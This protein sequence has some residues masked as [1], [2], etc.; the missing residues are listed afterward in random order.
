M[1]WMLGRITGILAALACLAPTLAL[2]DEVVHFGPVPAWVRPTTLPTSN[3]RFEGPVEVLLLDVESR[4][5]PEGVETFTD[6]AFRIR[7][8]AGLA[9]AGNVL[10]A[11]DPASDTLTVHSLQII[12]NGQTTDITQSG[13]GFL[14]LR[15][16]TD[17]S[18]AMLNGRLTANRLVEGLQV[19]DTVRFS[20][21]LRHRDLTMP[22]HGEQLLPA[23]IPT[24][25]ALFRQRVTWPSNHPIQ[26]RGAS[27]LGRLAPVRTAEGFELV[28][29][30]RNTSARTPIPDAP[31]RYN[32]P[33]IL[34]FTDFTTWRDISTRYEPLFRQA[35]T[36]R[37]DSPLHA[38]LE[39]IRAAS[40]DPR[41]R[42]AAALALVEQRVRYFA[43]ATGNGGYTPAAADQTWS[44][45][46]GDCKGKTAL[47]LA[48][49][50]ELGIE[51]EPA[52]VSTTFHDGLDQHL[53]LLSWF[54]HVIV[55]VTIES[56]V[57]WLDATRLGD[58]DLE[59]LTPPGHQWALAIRPGGA[60]LEQIR[61]P[62]PDHPLE[63]ETID[64][65]ASGGIDEPADIHIEGRYFGDLAVQARAMTASMSPQ[66]QEQ[67][68]R[69]MLGNDAAQLRSVRF[70]PSGPD[71][72]YAIVSEHR[73]DSPWRDL[74]GDIRELRIDNS[75]YTQSFAARTG[76]PDVPYAL[77][78][79]YFYH[80]TQRVRL[81]RDGQGFQ[82]VGEDVHE[83][84]GP[85][86][87]NRTSRISE[88]VATID[89]QVRNLAGEVS[90]AEAR[91]LETRLSALPTSRQVIIRVTGYHMTLAEAS[92]LVARSPGQARPLIVRAG[93][94]S[95]AH[96]REAAI[97]DLTAALR[98]EPHNV[99]ALLARGSL[100]SE[101]G[102]HTAAL[103]DADEA[104]RLSPQDPDVLEA[105]SGMRDRASLTALSISDLDE[106]LRLS[107]ASLQLLNA[108]CWRKVTRNVDLPGA[109]QD[110][111]HALRIN[112]RDAPT[113]DS[114]AMVNLRQGRLNE[115]LADYNSAL[116]IDPRQAASLYGRGITR[117]RQGAVAAGREDLAAALAIDPELTAT[118]AGYG[119]TPEWAS[120]VA[121]PSPAHSQPTGPTPAAPPP[122]AGTSPPPP[123][124]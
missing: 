41:A 95:E 7:N 37:P 34:E 90:A 110:C 47:L 70:E 18:R 91:R 31:R 17:L 54:D 62:V 120:Q 14:V 63:T 46:Y 87:I 28:L 44:R 22:D 118:F 101:Q 2:A 107:P 98:L 116:Q 106:A 50:N 100:Y 113:L 80:S 82:I 55:R 39:R 78:F 92:A 109:E 23:V 9:A 35:A 77:N 10:T 88:G 112:P 52:L 83:T 60:D 32:L 11:S 56:R 93:V 85:V 66:Q 67:A 53:P 5:G 16:E 76:N 84:I 81:P 38:E 26:F 68:F 3:E 48:L 69:E 58:S 61:Q 73:L 115:A 75:S 4:L 105:R 45:R 72:S 49:L 122:S 19:G 59:S 43:M 71:G 65:D 119:L 21:S 104:V 102:N 94:Q 27:E 30:R 86:E 1:G 108:R 111:E 40:Q 74:P 117:I 99:D 13:D 124:P 24:S 89:F 15:Q 29:E 103:A 6:T 97:T 33:P 57:Y 42:A 64:Y 79:P 8:E 25:V 12:R 51:A 121:R 20:A 123:R 114:R 36:L 96:Q